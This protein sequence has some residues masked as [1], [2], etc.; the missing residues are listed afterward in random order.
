[1]N[2]K[3]YTG[4]HRLLGKE[5]GQMKAAR[6]ILCSFNGAWRWKKKMQICAIFAL[7]GYVTH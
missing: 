3:K 5:A 6:Q 7:K 2:Q 1:M 4:V